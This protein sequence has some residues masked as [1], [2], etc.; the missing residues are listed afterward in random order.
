MAFETVLISIFL[1]STVVSVSLVYALVRG[2][3]WVC[4]RMY[5]RKMKTWADGDKKGEDDDSLQRQVQLKNP[6]PR[7]RA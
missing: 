5:R 4:R 3:E 7:H 1:G 6:R 2:T